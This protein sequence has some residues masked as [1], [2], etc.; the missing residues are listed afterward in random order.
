[1]RKPPS[2]H[3]TTLSIFRVSNESFTLDDFL[4]GDK[5]TQ[6]SIFQQWEVRQSQLADISFVL[7]CPSGHPREGGAFIQRHRRRLQG[8]PMATETS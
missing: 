8:E 1:M 3:Y 4:R 2:D 7:T 6:D 5:A